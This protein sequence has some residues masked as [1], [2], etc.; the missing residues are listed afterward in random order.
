MFFK[1]R[2]ESELE[3]EFRRL[4]NENQKLLDTLLNNI[5]GGT[6]NGKGHQERVRADRR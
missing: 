2:S 3:L 6:E 5:D 4:M 1:K